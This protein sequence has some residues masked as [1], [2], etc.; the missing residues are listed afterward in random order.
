MVQDLFLSV[1]KINLHCA[2]TFLNSFFDI[3][4]LSNKFHIRKLGHFYFCLIFLFQVN[5][6]KLHCFLPFRYTVSSLV[7]KF[8]E[9]KNHF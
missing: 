6:L 5:N 3:K 7:I 1:F 8:R 2:D 4:N 9:K